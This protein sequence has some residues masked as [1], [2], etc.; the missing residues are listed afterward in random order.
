MLFLYRPQNLSS[1]RGKYSWLLALKNCIS[2]SANTVDS[3]PIDCLDSE[4]GGYD[5]LDSSTKLRILIFLCD[6]V[7]ETL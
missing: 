7:L 2:Q 1:S 5:T 4:A 3:L 6:E